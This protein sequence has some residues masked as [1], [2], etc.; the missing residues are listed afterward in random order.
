MGIT[1]MDDISA[2]HEC[3][4]CASTNIVR[5]LRREQ[6]ICRDCGLIFE[7]MPPQLEEA[8]EQGHGIEPRSIRKATK[9]KVTKK[10]TVKK[11]AKKKVA[12]KAVKKKAVKKKTAK[13]T[14][15]KKAAKK[16][17]AKKSSKKRR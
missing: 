16:K 17:V 8:F 14:T 6:I 2:I 4:D 11:V 1:M 15:K 9:K 10:K 5:S 3:P 7:P 12:K 13:K